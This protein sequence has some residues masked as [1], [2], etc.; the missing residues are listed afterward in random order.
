MSPTV[1]A[2]IANVAPWLTAALPG[3]LGKIADG[4][5]N[6]VVGNSS[7]LTDEQ[8][9]KLVS[10]D[11][12]F[13]LKALELGYKDLE[14][15]GAQQVEVIKTVNETMR[16]ESGSDHWPSYTWR[17]FIG[18]SFGCYINSLWLLPLFKIT[19]VIMNADLVLA[20][21]GILGVASWFRGKA[22]ADTNN[23]IAKG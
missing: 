13:K 22:Q 17:P 8:L 20:I 11:A 5:I 23:P 18:F 6:S 15:L 2:L 7:E 1:K 12:D 10:A 4:V 16:V 21:G 19:P 14:S 9:N 3:P